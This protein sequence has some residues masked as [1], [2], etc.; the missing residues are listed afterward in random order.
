MINLREFNDKPF[1]L[2]Q[3]RNYFEINFINTIII[4]N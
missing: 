4:N 2:Y 3:T 1:I